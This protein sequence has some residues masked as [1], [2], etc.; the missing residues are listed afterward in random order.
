MG[1]PT[2]KKE[3]ALKKTFSFLALLLLLVFMALPARAESSTTLT[4]VL[5]D[6]YSLDLV[7]RGKG[8]VKVGGTSCQSSTCLTL[9]RLEPITIQAMP[10]DGWLLHCIK[11]NGKAQSAQASG[12]TLVLDGVTEDM[13]LE[14]T[15]RST[16]VAPATGDDLRFFVGLLALSATC[17]TLCLKKRK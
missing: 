15:F 14:V 13:T 17:L 9:A 1:L 3:D 12:W 4:V 7:I 8:T 16:S 11:L 2:C 6:N 5:P 10:K